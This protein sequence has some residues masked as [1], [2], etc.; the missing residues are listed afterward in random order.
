MWFSRYSCFS[1]VC[2]RLLRTKR[3]QGNDISLRGFMT[4]RANEDSEFVDGVA[5]RAWSWYTVNTQQT[6]NWHSRRQRSLLIRD[7]DDW[8]S[9]AA[10]RGGG[11]LLF[12]FS[13]L[14]G[15]RCVRRMSSRHAAT[16]SC[17]FI[18]K[19][20]CGR[21]TV[22]CL[23]DSRCKEQPRESVAGVSNSAASF[24]MQRDSRRYA[25]ATIRRYVENVARQCSS[26]DTASIVRTS[27][28]GF[29]V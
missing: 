23:R 1:A 22:W 4:L 3:L 17:W 10:G 7:I 11:G 19:R 16:R 9:V 12:L 6:R 8:S 13:S 14:R 25:S 20:V 15:A 2:R 18:A 26:P 27:G 28:T 21:V 29:D 24:L 5:I